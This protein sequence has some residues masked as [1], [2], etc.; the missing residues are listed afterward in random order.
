MYKIK[1]TPTFE[2]DLKKL[3]RHIAKRIIE[4]IDWLAKNPKALGAPVKYLPKTLKGLRKYRVGD[5]RILFWLD[6]RNKMIILYGAE[7]RGSIYER[8]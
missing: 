7:H 8:F 2:E 5:W 3:D 1:F 4:K 6:Q